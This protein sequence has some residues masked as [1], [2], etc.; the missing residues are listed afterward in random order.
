MWHT[1]NKNQCGLEL[2]ERT[3]RWEGD[4][5]L[6]HLLG[7]QQPDKDVAIIPNHNGNEIKS[8]SKTLH[9]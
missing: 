3:N 8:A 2:I 9:T 1:A 6:R 7:L 4:F 5:R